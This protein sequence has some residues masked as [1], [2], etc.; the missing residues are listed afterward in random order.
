MH[1]RSTWKGE[2]KVLSSEDSKEFIQFESQSKE[3]NSSKSEKSTSIVQSFDELNINEYIFPRKRIEQM[4]TFKPNFTSG[5][6]ARISFE[7]L[8]RVGLHNAGNTCYLSSVLQC[9]TWTTPLAN[10]FLSKDHS[11][12]CTFYFIV[13]C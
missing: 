13:Y 10:Y 8:E 9:L 1:H 4:L 3:Q 7:Y 12:K 6:N 5:S 2:C 11:E